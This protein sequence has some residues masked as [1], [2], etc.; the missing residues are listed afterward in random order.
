MSSSADVSTKAEPV[1]IGI[2]DL[3]NILGGG[4]TGNRAYLLEGTPGSGKT[5]IAL[6]FL[7]EGA[8]RGD[9]G[10]YITLSETAAELREVARSH[11][12]DLS[13][14]E[15]FELVSR[16]GLDPEAEQSILEP[17]E[18]EL[19]E[20]IQG[21]IECVDRL[22]PQRV[23]FD[24]LSE[25]R[26]LAQNSLR[27]RRQIL[28][29]KQ[30]FSLRGCTVLML[31][32]RSSDPGD[33]QLHSIAHGVIT[34][35]QS[36]QEYGTERRRLRVVKMRGV[37]Y[38]GGFHDF[39]I[40][41]G[42]VAVFPRL[43][44][45]EHHTNFTEHLV[46]TG[47]ERL[48][49]MLGGG[50]ATGTNALFNGPSGVGKTSTAVQCA[51]A[52]I[53]H[54]QKVAY[55]LFDE[56]RAT[57]LTRAKALG[58]D[59]APHLESGALKVVQIDPAELTPGEFASWVRDAVE[60]EGIDFLVIDSLNAFLQA[61]PGE[62]YLILQMHEML[63]YL[64]QQGVIT[65]LILGQ[66]GT[67]GDVRSEVDLSYLSDT[68]VIFRYFESSGE[69]L[70]AISVAKSRTTAHESTI[71]EFRLGRTGLT[72]GVPLKDFEGVLSGLP[73]YRGE[74]AL[75]GAEPAVAER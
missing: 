59:L 73:T 4:L 36:T 2:P 69:M 26:L 39:T 10:L 60:K 46:S 64:N 65:L 9:R 54:G 49:Q 58:M 23:V 35:E 31:D 55:Y 57:L 56:G 71:R 8:R 51:I 32:D 20:T 15:L 43:I 38:R 62:K 75:L 1:S 53:G 67:I 68:I 52:A 16:D 27:Y 6:Q 44:A 33:L 7:L 28:A 25:M 72:I 12:W 34:L 30:Y 22:R 17:N 45:A 5:T 48:D 37:K 14:I 29:L 61:M 18:V 21:V 70:K 41:T 40:E 24:S 47:V 42:G 11:D 63:S 66:H 50:L 3:D 19:G 13:G 74:T